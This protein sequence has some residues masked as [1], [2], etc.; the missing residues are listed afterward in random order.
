MHLRTMAV[1]TVA[2]GTVAVDIGTVASGGLPQ[3]RLR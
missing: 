3:P 2:I 1:I